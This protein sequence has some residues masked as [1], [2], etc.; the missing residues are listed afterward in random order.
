MGPGRRARAWPRKLSR[1]SGCYGSVAARGVFRQS[2]QSIVRAYVLAK[3]RS[4]EWPR[5][6][7]RKRAR[8]AV[9]AR[10]L[11]RNLH[12]PGCAARHGSVA[13]LRLSAPV[14]HSVDERADCSAGIERKVFRREIFA[15]GSR[16][17]ALEPLSLIGKENSPAF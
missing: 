15:N 17:C 13:W 16:P 1:T 12:L 7:H 10:K 5:D 14:Y 11:E 4:A 6:R 9:D 8:A 2:G 3:W